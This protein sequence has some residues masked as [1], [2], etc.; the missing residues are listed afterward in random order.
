VSGIDPRGVGGELALQGQ[1]LDVAAL[2]QRTI[3]ANLANQATPGWKRLEVEFE[4][5]FA[6]AS[7]D[8]RSGGP[9]SAEAT[10]QVDP[11]ASDRKDGGTVDAE[12]ELVDMS[13]N[14]LVFQTLTRAASAKVANLRA[15][16]TGR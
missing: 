7:R 5:A 10:V 12:R 9:A 6:E 11:A 14:A 16:I 2:R 3:A 1:L 4:E 15:A 13:R 8:A